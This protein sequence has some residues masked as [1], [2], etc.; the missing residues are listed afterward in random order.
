MAEPLKTYFDERI[1]H[2]IARQVSAVWEQFPVKDFLT[3]VLDGFDSLELMDRGR[4]IAR[5]LARHL[6]AD[7]PRA[8]K[9]LMSSIGAR[10]PGDLVEGGMASFFYLPH[11]CFVAQSGIGHFDESMRAQH[12]L[13]QL[14]SAEFSIRPFIER[15]DEKALALLKEWAKDPSPH[16]RRLVSEGTRPRLPW[17]ARLRG[18]QQDPSPVLALLELLKD[19]GELYVR[20]SVANNL[21]DIGKDHPEVLISVAR[22]WMKGASEERCRLVRHALRSLVRQ[23]NAE[24]LDILGFGEVAALSIENISITPKRARRGGKVTLVFDVRS[25]SRQTQR[26]LLDLRV[27]FIKSNGTASPKVFRMKAV[28]LRAGEKDT[29]KKTVS[30]ADL[31]TR[32]HHVGR[33]VVDVLVNGRIMPLGS[34][35]LL[36][37]PETSSPD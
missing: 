26:V 11:T 37:T 20:R 29:F 21:N 14:F 12:M 13:T 3:D 6:P 8:L 22:R 24:A 10:R 28:N 2:A 31:T 16:V 25:T 23:G 15:Y 17:A 35:T 30:L 18:F 36:A 33:H 5:A 19:D 9:I 7:Y 27:H 34:F 4:Y 32:K 1:P